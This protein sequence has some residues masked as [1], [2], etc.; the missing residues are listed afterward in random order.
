MSDGR[1]RSAWRRRVEFSFWVE[2]IGESIG[3]RM[4]GQAFNGPKQGGWKGTMNLESFLW[5]G[6]FEHTGGRASGDS[7][8]LKGAD[9]REDLGWVVA[10]EVW[11]E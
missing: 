9:D 4:H 6:F 2:R 1:V 8:R 3:C 5:R 11:W 10:F 7:A